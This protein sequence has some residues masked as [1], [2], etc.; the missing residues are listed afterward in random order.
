[1]DTPHYLKRITPVTWLA[2]CRWQI[3]N[4]SANGG[5]RINYDWLRWA[6]LVPDSKL[7][8]NEGIKQSNLN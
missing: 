5:H 6:R 3:W 4:L 2:V 8:A 1:M 7:I